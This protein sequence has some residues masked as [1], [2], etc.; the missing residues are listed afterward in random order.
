MRT[1]RGRLSVEEAPEAYPDSR[2]E[3]VAELALDSRW[4]PILTIVGCVD[5]EVC[6]EVRPD[7]RRGNMK[8]LDERYVWCNSLL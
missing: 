7:Q 5:V 6:G 2:F 1:M 4:M 3:G 8:V